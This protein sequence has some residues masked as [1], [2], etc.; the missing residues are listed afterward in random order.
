MM[1]N[2]FSENDVIQFIDPVYRFCMNHLNNYHDAEDLA[3]EI[4]LHIIDGFG[5]YEIKSLESWVWKIVH[6]R[7][8]RL[9][10]KR[11]NSPSMISD[12]ILMMFGEYDESFDNVILN[13]DYLSVF[14]A[15]HSMSADY[16]NIAVDYYIG[17]MS[18]HD[19]A[20]RYDI[21]ESTVKWRLNISREK[22]RERIGEYEMEKI[23]K[24]LNWN[25]ST[26]NGSMDPSKYLKSQT[27]R[28]ICEAA[29]EKPLTIEEISMRTGI[30]AMYVEDEMNDLLYG[31]AI[32]KEGNKYVTNFIILR[33][34]DQI[35]MIEYIKPLI[36]DCANY[37][38]ELFKG[39]ENTDK[40]GYIIVPETIRGLLFNTKNDLGFVNGEY[41]KRQDGG[42]G[43]FIVSETPDEC[44]T[45]AD[46]GA[47]KNNYYHENK[48]IVYYWIGKYFNNS[49][50]RCLNNFENKDC[51][52]DKLS[53]SE[54]IK[55]LEC[56]LL[57]KDGDS[58]KFN[59]PCFTSES[60]NEFISPYK[61]ESDK[62]HELAK[63]LI[64]KIH[65]AFAAFTP[66]H[67]GSQ[68]N[69]YMSSF[70]SSMSSYIIEELQN[71]NVLADPGDNLIYNIYFVDKNS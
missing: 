4:M 49:I 8:A 38:E 22:L 6:N 25:T 23:Y 13:E 41:P 27:E 47:G 43:W 28:A 33:L 65:D 21:T 31:D 1:N 51:Q 9:I 58:Y 3:S 34:K 55:M 16:R 7:Y 54:L 50:N 19:I 42:F 26:C 56:N 60:F 61:V 32:I 24:Q 62:L 17:E 2:N 5:K 20:N 63:Q 48:H 12:E 57:I 64:I 68:I 30:P 66:K 36:K 69:Q 52:I 15:L 53:E 71:R 45:L 37:Y 70:L 67:L 35:K 14:K 59:F 29:Y 39:K 46:Y 11:K 18:V 40:L 44:G 10:N